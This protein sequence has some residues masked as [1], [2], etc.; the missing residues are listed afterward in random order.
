MWPLKKKSGLNEPL[1]VTSATI[2]CVPGIWNG[3]DEIKNAIFSLTGGE[4]LIVGDMLI[5]VERERHYKLEIRGRDERVKHAFKYAG[6]ATTISEEFLNELE[7]HNYLVYISGETGSLTE[8]ENI[9]FAAAA[10][11][12]TGG[13]GIKIETAGKAF[14]KNRWLQLIKTFEET[15]LYQMFV[16][17]ATTDKKDLVW[18]CGMHNL[19][20]KDSI[21]SGEEYQKA[22]DLITIFGYYQIFDKPT[23]VPNQIFQPGPQSPQYKITNE[24]NQPYRNIELFE[25]PYGMWRLTKI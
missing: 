13:I 18:S 4:Y 16:A 7:K 17:D 3:I 10:V 5:S 24:R 9:A 15:D 22:L 19:G 8:A 20:L 23:I 1:P 6:A 25:N 12:K 14:E 2:I 11:L 21:V